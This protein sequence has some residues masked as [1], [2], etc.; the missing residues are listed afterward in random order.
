MKIILAHAM[1]MAQLILSLS[2]R[3]SNTPLVLLYAPV[4]DVIMVNKFAIKLQTV[5]MCFFH[6]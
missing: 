1:I 4:F 5:V 3:A 6:V 2:R